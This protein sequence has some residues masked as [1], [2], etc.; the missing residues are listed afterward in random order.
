MNGITQLDLSPHFKFFLYFPEGVLG[1]YISTIWA[2]EENL[3]GIAYAAGYFDQA[4]FIHDFRAM[5]GLTPKEYG[6]IRPPDPHR[7]IYLY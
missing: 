2:S 7:V 3:T 4:H 1:R 6:L 5:T